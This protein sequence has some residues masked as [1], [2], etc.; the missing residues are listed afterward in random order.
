MAP[1]TGLQTP[2]PALQRYATAEVPQLPAF[3]PAPAAA[4]DADA[5]A[6]AES[7]LN[8]RWTSIDHCAT[9]MEAPGPI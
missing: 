5:V 3:A 4:D 2:D 1:A 6:D 8:M 7:T 9:N